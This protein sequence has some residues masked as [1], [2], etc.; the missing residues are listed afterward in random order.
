ME[1]RD[2]ATVEIRLKGPSAFLATILAQ[3]GSFAVIVGADGSPLRAI[4][5]LETERVVRRDGR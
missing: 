5:I 2:P 1:A 4:T 3:L